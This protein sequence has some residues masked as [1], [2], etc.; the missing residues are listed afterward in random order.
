MILVSGDIA[1]MPMDYGFDTSS[2][3]EKFKASYY[4][5]MLKVLEEL[6][7]IHHILYYI[8]GNVIS[9]LTCSLLNCNISV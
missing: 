9:R 2:E 5:D 1:D 6:N 7:K 4:E 3:A 8:P